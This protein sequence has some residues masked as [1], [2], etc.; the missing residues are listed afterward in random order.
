[1]KPASTVWL[2]TSLATRFSTPLGLNHLEG[3]CANAEYLPEEGSTQ[4]KATLLPAPG[5]ERERY[6]RAC[7]F[8]MAFCACAVLHPS[9]E[10]GS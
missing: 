8:W 7:T 1:M 5:D 6:E 10:P 9:I 2:Y 4:I 3:L